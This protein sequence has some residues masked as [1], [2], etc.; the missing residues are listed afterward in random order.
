VQYAGHP[1]QQAKQDVDDQV[2]S[3][4]SLSI[5]VIRIAEV[6]S[7]GSFLGIDIS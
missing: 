4:E 6:G 3:G 5:A 1:H 7:I 2:F